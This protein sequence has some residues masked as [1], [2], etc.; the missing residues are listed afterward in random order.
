MKCYNEV[1][2][3]GEYQAEN[4]KQ[5]KMSLNRITAAWT[6]LTPGYGY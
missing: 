5:F 2:F 4:L 6:N 1:Y 3:S